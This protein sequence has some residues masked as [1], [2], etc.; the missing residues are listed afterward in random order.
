MGEGRFVTLNWQQRIDK[1]AE[2]SI[3]SLPGR[4]TVNVLF[5]LL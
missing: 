3:D 2:Y 1:N 4:S 5:E